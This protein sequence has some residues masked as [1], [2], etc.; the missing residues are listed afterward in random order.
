MWREIL[1][2]LDNSLHSLWGM[3]VAIAL[4]RAFDARVTGCHVYAVKLHDSRFKAMEYT[5]PERYLR[6]GELERQREVHNLLIEKGMQI[7]SD[8]Y[9]D[10]ARRRCEEFQVPFRGLSLEGKNYRRL[11]EEGNGGDYDLVVLGSHGMGAVEDSLIG[12][13]AARCARMMRKDLLIVKEERPIRKGTPLLVCIDGSP[14]SYGA[15]STGM[16]LARRFDLH[17][18]A[19]AVYDPYFHYVAFNSISRVLSEEGARVF[20]FREQEE[21]HRTIIDDGLARIYGSYLAISKEM[22]KERDIPIETHLLAGK[23][24]QE[25]L[26]FLKRIDP[27][28][29]IAGRF[30]SHGDDGLDIGG[31]TENLLLKGGTSILVSTRRVFPPDGLIREETMRWTEGAERLLRK[32]PPF[33][34][35]M[36]RGAIENYARKRGHTVVTRSV[37]EEAVRVLMPGHLEKLLGK[38]D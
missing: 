16:E 30:G 22:A 28:L 36:A 31:T 35:G 2:G 23:A 26:G 29:I 13:V 10:V 33:A 9:I 5:L 4:A 12:S 27:C 25:I 15:L 1:V 32:A 17:L 21:L 37:M 6:D 24:Y 11:V 7:I 18:H 3:E 14:Y 38:D 20:R 19:V 8:S 34:R